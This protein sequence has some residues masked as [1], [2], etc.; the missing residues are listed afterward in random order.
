MAETEM[1]NPSYAEQTMDYTDLISESVFIGEYP[2]ETI[3]EGL[4]DQ[5]E[6]YLST[7]DHVN[8]VDVFFKQYRESIQ[9]IENNPDDHPEERREVLSTI[10]DEFLILIRDLFSQRLNITIILLDDESNNVDDIEVVLRPLYEFFILNARN[11]FIKVISADVNGKLPSTPMDNKQFI[12]EVNSLLSVYNPI[13]TT[14]PVDTFLK[15]CGE[16]DILNM[17]TTN[18]WTGNF[19]KKYSPKLYQ[20][21]DLVSDI[22]TNIAII[23]EIKEELNNG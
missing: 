16:E 23:H 8:Y 11:N 3:H 22:I 1:M 7:D 13:I 17:I 6:N 18:Q 21:D 10:L 14:I 5:F 9:T 15:I 4:Q 20:N 2:P 12:R 19:L